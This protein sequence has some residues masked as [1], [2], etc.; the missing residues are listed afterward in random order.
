MATAIGLPAAENIGPTLWKPDQ[1]A[2]ALA[3]SSRKL[4]AMTN[5]GEI[6]CVRLGRAVRYDPADLLEW[7]EEQK[8]RCG[9]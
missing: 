6:P 2:R 9:G 4:W 8:G 5:A 1:A 7:I 3:I